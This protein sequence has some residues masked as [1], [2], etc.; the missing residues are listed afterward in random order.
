MKNIV[1]ECPPYLYIAQIAEHCPKALFTYLQLWREKDRKNMIRISP[2]EVRI[3]FLITLRKFNHDLMLLVREGLV[4]IE[5]TS[6]LIK[7]ELVGWQEE[8]DLC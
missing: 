3:E 5:E 4:S 7:I 2:N 1:E 8:D 6:K